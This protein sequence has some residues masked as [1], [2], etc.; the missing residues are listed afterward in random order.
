M[1][2]IDMGNQFIDGFEAYVDK[3]KSILFKDLASAQI[4]MFVRVLIKMYVNSNQ[5]AKDETN[6][7]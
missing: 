5:L 1:Y 6:N 2:C 7:P 3:I 4:E